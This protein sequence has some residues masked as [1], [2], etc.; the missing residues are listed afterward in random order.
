MQEDLVFQL[1]E[2]TN[3]PYSVQYVVDHLQVHAVKKAA[4]Q[5]A[6]DVLVE[7]GQVMEK[8]NGK[9]KIYY[10]NQGELEKLEPEELWAC[11]Q[12]NKLMQ[13]QV[14]ALSS[15][16]KDLERKKRSLQ[17]QKS[18]AEL[19]EIIDKIKVGIAGNEQRLKD[20]RGPNAVDEKKVAMVEAG[21]RKYTEAWAKYKRIWGSLWDP[22]SEGLNLSGKKEREFLA[23][24]GVD[25]DKDA[26]VDLKEFR[27]LLSNKR[28][29]R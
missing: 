14:A 1:L 26:G 21:F 10:Q 12:E 2:K 15:E 9:A 28:A 27:A 4:A 3:K 25:T 22:V 8:V 29:R 24:M 5:R 19:R 11:Q 13:Q 7:K 17:I 18:P 23:D 6:L 16:V 20:M